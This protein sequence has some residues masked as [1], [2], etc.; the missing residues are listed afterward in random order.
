MILK[1]ILQE[2]YFYMS[3]QYNV[4]LSK[5]D[6]KMFKIWNK[7]DPVSKWERIKNKRVYKLQGNKNRFIN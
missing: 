7:Q 5:R 6:I 1:E 4:K 3:E 2:T